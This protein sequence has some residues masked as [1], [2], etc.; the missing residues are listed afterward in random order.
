MDILFR[1]FIVKYS[2][3]SFQFNDLMEFPSEGHQGNY[4]NNIVS[5]IQVITFFA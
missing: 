3:L 5:Q 1:L 4:L 2:S